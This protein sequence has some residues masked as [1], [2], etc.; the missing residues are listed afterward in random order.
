MRIELYKLKKPAAFDFGT[1]LDAIVRTPLEDR[2]RA[3]NANFIRLE[4]HEQRGGLWLCD[5]VKI[6]MDHGPSKAGLTQPAKGFELKNDE[7]F[8][9]ET[10]FLWDST[11]DWCVIQYNHFGVRPSA[12]AEYLSLF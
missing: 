2:N 4:T 10:A 1:R 11:N 7:G 5:F 12:I 9:E 6:R 3:R 8:G